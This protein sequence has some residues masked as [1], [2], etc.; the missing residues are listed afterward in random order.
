MEHSLQY[1]LSRVGA[2]KALGLEVIWNEFHRK[3]G[4]EGV[5]IELLPLLQSVAH[6]V[7]TQQERDAAAKLQSSQHSNPLQATKSI[8]TDKAV[9][10]RRTI[11]NPENDRENVSANHRNIDVSFCSHLVLF[12]I[13]STLIS[14]SLGYM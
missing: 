6:W 4:N 2:I 14:T 12:R 7:S 13:V 9:V 11:T 1:P 10:P 3:E 8:Q 5:Q